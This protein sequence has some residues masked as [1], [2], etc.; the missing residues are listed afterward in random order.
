MSSNMYKVILILSAT[1]L[2]FILWIIYLANTAQPSVFFNFVA[3]IPYGDKVGHFC[4]F[5][6]LS[7]GANFVFKLKKFSLGLF[8]VYWGSAAVLFFV[9][10]EE[11]SQYFIPNRTLDAT[12]LIADFLGIIV[13]NFITLFI[14]L[15][16]YK[17]IK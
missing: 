6:F 11:L 4:L 15:Y 2:G 12:D 17:S 10:I 3:S 14:S 5:G 16:S 1:F 9:V 13:F 7:L 8:N